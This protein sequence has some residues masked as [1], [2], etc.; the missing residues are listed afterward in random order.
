MN[1]IKDFIKKSS[2]GDWLFRY[3]RVKRC[4]RYI[5]SYEKQFCKWSSTNLDK[6]DDDYIRLRL[7]L[8]THTIEKGLSHKHFKAGF[9]RAAVVELY[10]LA[11][12][13]IACGGK[14]IFALDNAISVLSEYHLRNKEAGFDDSE[15]LTIP[16]HDL[17]NV[18]RSAGSKTYIL[19]NKNDN[20]PFSFEQFAFDRS[21]VRLYDEKGEIV[22][23]EELKECIR[24]A[25]TAPN[26]C[27]RQSVRVHVLTDDS[28]FEDIERL[29]LGCR[30]FG[31]NASAFIFITNDLSLYESNEFKLPIF[32]AG[33]FT[34]NLIYAMFE[35]GLYSCILN[36]S[37]PNDTGNEI[38]R[39]AGI[40]DNESING[41][42]AV[43]KISKNTEISVPASL[44]RKTEE[45]TTFI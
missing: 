12:Q 17:E 1:V 35:K 4:K 3:R 10:T 39:L 8:T 5:K 36:A 2:F 38:Y 45:I 33:V 9:G 43:Y 13:Y 31:T 20:Q 27:N 41:L 18:Y 40:P 44:R 22:S 32:E 28:K 7:L 23:R 19:G 14:D 24:I 25:Q 29:Q 34:M 16:S 21:S 11:K 15:Y 30:G 26:A 6:N 42:I 37:F